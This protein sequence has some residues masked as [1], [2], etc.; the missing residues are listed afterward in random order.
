M[1]TLDKHLSGIRTPKTDARKDWSPNAAQ[2]V[3]STFTGTAER[4]PIHDH[5]DA[6]RRGDARTLL[7]RR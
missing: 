7:R 2:V 6:I 1:P 5:M 4:D 3:E